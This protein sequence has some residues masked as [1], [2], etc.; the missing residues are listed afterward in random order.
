M[1]G[2]NNGRADPF[3]KESK[4]AVTSTA[5][6]KAAV[7]KRE[8][9]IRESVPGSSYYPDFNVPVIFRP[10]EW[11]LKP[12]GGKP[13]PKTGKAKEI[14]GHT[15]MVKCLIADETHP[16]NTPVPK[17]F[18]EYYDVWTPKPG[19]EDQYDFGAARLR[20]LLRCVIP[21]EQLA[22]ED[23]TADEANWPTILDE[24]CE[25]G[26][27]DGQPLLIRATPIKRPGK[28]YV[29]QKTKQVKPGRARRYLDSPEEF[30]GEQGTT[31]AQG[32]DV[33][34]AEPEPEPVKAVVTRRTRATVAR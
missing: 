17:E 29:D 1:A 14:M 33:G 28:D 3:S 2:Q 5:A 12:M 34:A 6:F 23:P 18:T 15:Y 8:Q 13:D 32:D 26:S 10:L 20:G 31:D 4:A 25:A 7:A 11:G 19:K 27:N 21:A 30:L 16:G 24:I 9:A 22:E